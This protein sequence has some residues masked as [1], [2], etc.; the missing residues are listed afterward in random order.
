MIG[1]LSGITKPLGDLPDRVVAAH[2][3]DP[4]PCGTGMLF[5]ILVLI[6][7]RFPDI[8][9]NMKLIKVGGDHKNWGVDLGGGSADADDV[10]SGMR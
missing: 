6:D 2:E 10:A 5:I 7:L 4:A 8:C 3:H 9:S 1:I